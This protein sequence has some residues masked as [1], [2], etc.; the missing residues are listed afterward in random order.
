MD[1]RDSMKNAL[2]ANGGAAAY[3][4]NAPG[5]Y[6][7]KQ[8]EYLNRGTKTFTQKYAKYSSTYVSARV[9][10]LD[11][12]NPLVWQTRMV[13]LADIVRPS[14]AILRRADNYKMVLF[15]DRDVEYLPP[16][17]KIETMGS[18]WLVTNPF[19]ISGGDGAGIVERCNAVWNHLDYYGKVVSEPMV[20]TNRRAD[21]NDPDAQQGNLI[22]KGYFTAEL[23]YNAETAQ[24]DTNTR[25]ILG[26]GAYKVT[27]YSDFLQEFTGDYG[28]VRLIEFTLRYEEPNAQ[29]DDMENHVAGGKAFSWEVSSAG[30]R[31]LPVGRSAKFYAASRRMGETVRGTEEHP[32]SYRWTSS[33]EAVAT[34]DETGRVTAVSEGTA[35]IRAALAQNPAHFAETG[36]EVMAAE[37]AGA[38]AFT[39]AVPESI[40]PFADATITAA[41]FEANG[42]ETDA[43]ISW[44]ASGAVDG[45][46]LTF[47]GPKSCTVYCFGYS[48][49]PLTVTAR[50]G[51]HS[52]SAEI[53]LEGL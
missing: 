23:Q 16:G 8:F 30:A 24:I 3:P 43:A 50:Y 45:T 20:V 22:T 15:A 41:W 32:V 14:A 27:G 28:S 7:D 48:G 13:R 1:I 34:V 37:S 25:M 21:A 2:L 42:A 6:A 17:A 10:G 26:T 12:A 18:V 5:Q 44:E 53:R 51:A 9:Q 29:I 46:Y 49:T 39:S 52:V 40:S 19:N 47:F 11:A 38:V 36:V 31:T 4:T 33:D 35:V